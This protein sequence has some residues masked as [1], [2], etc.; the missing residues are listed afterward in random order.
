MEETDQY[1]QEELQKLLGSLT[2]EQMLDAQSYPTAP[3]KESVNK[4]FREIINHDKSRVLAKLGYLKEEEVGSIKIPVRTYFH[5]ST[6]AESEG[7]Q[8]V[9][10]YLLKRAADLTE[11]SLS[12]NAKWMDLL[13]AVKRSQQNIASP[14]TT[15]KKGL[16]GTTTV[17][18]GENA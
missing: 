3:E 4:I 16:F 7:N 15:K 9:S 6:Y 14:R 11:P 12:I 13:I 17:K 5:F 2:Q 10:E 18:E 1:D 8:K